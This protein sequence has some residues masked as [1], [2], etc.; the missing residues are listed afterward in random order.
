MRS[1]EGK[2]ESQPECKAGAYNNLLVI[3]TGDRDKNRILNFPRKF[4]I[5]FN[6]KPI[7]AFF[8]RKNG[9]LEEKNCLL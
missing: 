6:L 3:G 4:S 2:A 9:L 5:S 7:S 1:G 8:K